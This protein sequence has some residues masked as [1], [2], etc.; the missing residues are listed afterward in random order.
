MTD[1]IREE[2]SAPEAPSGTTGHGHSNLE[3]QIRSIAGQ[4]EVRYAELDRRL[5]ATAAEWAA[6]AETISRE[7]ERRIASLTSELQRLRAA[8]QA[9]SAA[10]QRSTAKKPAAKKP[11]AKKPAKQPAAKGKKA[12]AR[13][14]KR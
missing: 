9:R 12:P 10:A 2:A 6:K 3:D 11:A 7:A 4:L 13:G 5:S 8:L 1:E 14:R